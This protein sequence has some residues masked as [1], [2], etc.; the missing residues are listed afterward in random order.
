M[1]YFY[2]FEITQDK[3]AI[4]YVTFNGDFNELGNFYKQFELSWVVSD[5]IS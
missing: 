2:D 5:S 1:C 4:S 3:L